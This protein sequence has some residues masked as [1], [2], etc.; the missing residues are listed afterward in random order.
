MHV[1]QV[2]AFPQGIIFSRILYRVPLLGTGCT[3]QCLLQLNV[4]RGRIILGVLTCC[5]TSTYNGICTPLFSGKN[6][7][8]STF[9]DTSYTLVSFMLRFPVC[10]SSVP[11]P[12]VVLLPDTVTV[13]KS[14]NLASSLPVAAHPPLLSKSVMRNSSNHKIPVLSVHHRYRPVNR[15]KR[16][17]YTQH[18][19]STGG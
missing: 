10:E 19:C 12:T 8:S 7:P 1:G 14:A 15:F 5:E 4:R 16:V 9:P 6:L 3:F 2:K 17:A 11:K 18:H 13:A